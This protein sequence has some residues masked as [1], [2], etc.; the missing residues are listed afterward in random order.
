MSRLIGIDLGTSTTEAAVFRDGKT[1]MILNPEGQEVTPSAVGL[2]QEGNWIFGARARAQYLLFPD[3]TAIEVKRKTGGSE[4]IRLGNRD[5]APV[6]LQARLLAHV[7]EYASAYLQEEVTRA[8]ISVPAY[9]TDLQRRETIQA[10]EMAGFSVERILNEP[11]AAAMSYGMDHLEEESHVLVY[12]LG[13]GT[14]D[15]TL[16]EMFGGVLEVRASAGDNQL[17]G[18]D[19]DDCLIGYLCDR[20][21]KKYGA[22]LRKDARAMVLLKQEAEKA[23][24]LLSEQEICR[25]LIPAIRVVDG[26]PRE[27][28]ETVS[29]LQFEEMTSALLQRTHEP[30]DRVLT[31]ADLD[32][33]DLDRV[34]L[35]G[36]STRMPMVAADLEEYLGITP[37]R[38]V[39]PDYAVAE[40]ASIMGGII[41]EE[42]AEEGLVITDV[43]PFT[44]GV[45]SVNFLDMDIMSEIIPRN[46]T[47]PVTRSEEFSTVANGQRQVRVEVYQGENPAASQNHYLGEFMLSG[48]P[49]APAGKESVDIAFS[50]DLN[51]IL[52]VKATVVSTGKEAAKTI[53]MKQG[54]E[55]TDVSGWRDAPGAEDYRSVIRAAERKGREDNL[56]PGKRERLETLIW[57]LKDALIR[58]DADQAKETGEDLDNL[59]NEEDFNPWRNDR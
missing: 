32:G 48:I 10:G 14:F 38:A 54:A 36:G 11:T 40:G 12:D 33:S 57:T 8:V 4:R 47:I 43:C 50:Y 26:V 39:H 2:D 1:E 29:R 35:V 31:D 41:S 52:N 9:F 44:L 16:L 56:A 18:K 3:L 53:N 58:Q 46:T 24:M 25:V 15:V 27:L 30:I 51:G 6:E 55:K 37:S 13:G 34:I 22:D 59:I 19:F 28:D 45:R 21:R 17:G 23:K 20:F 7:R 5:Y 42:M 49:P